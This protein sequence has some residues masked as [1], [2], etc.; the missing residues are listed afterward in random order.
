MIIT[1]RGTVKVDM[2]KEI[3]EI[4]NNFSELI[5]GKVS[6]LAGRNL[7]ESGDDQPIRRLTKI[8]EEEFHSVTAKLS[9]VY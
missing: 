2:R 7:F 4:I 6:S 5:E 3:T 9:F 1:D 8:Q